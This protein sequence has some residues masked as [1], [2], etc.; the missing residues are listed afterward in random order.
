[1][2]LEIKLKNSIAIVKRVKLI[3]VSP[4]DKHLKTIENLWGL[5]QGL[6]FIRKVENWIYFDREKELF[7]RVTEP[8]HR[9]K[10]QLESELDWMAFLSQRK[11]SLVAP[12]PSN[13]SQLIEVVEDEGIVFF[14]SVFEKAPG[15][16]LKKP[17]D[18]KPQ[19][20][21]N[22]GA[23]IGKIH[24]ETINYI[25]GSEVEKRPLWNADNNHLNIEKLSQGTKFNEH[26]I[27]LNEYLN[28][29][30]KDK[31]VFNLI[32]GDIHHGNFLVSGDKVTLFDFDDSIYHWFLYDLV[33][34]FYLFEIS[35]KEQVQREELD[36]IFKE[37][38]EGY[39]KFSP[40]S[41]K[42]LKFFD[43]FLLYRDF[44][45]YYWGIKHESSGSISK[46]AREWVL[47]MIP[48]FFNRIE[49]FDYRTLL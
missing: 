39:F 27:I 44:I 22:W 8:S 18:F 12:K 38:F 47:K 3:M 21:F 14:V 20:M 41:K 28:K 16:A 19:T 36:L 49:N 7:V 4:T 42:W 40:L 43:A 26:F 46:V 45:M 25:P 48:Y 5:S 33:V 1:M 31:N 30:P 11:I 9:Q 23:V 35:F 15:V 32:H 24:T 6:E 34:P 29:L 13:S 37:F 2:S 17:S 10:S